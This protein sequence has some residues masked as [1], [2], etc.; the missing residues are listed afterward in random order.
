[1]KRI[2]NRIARESPFN[3]RIVAVMSLGGAIAAT[4]SMAAV[5]MANASCPDAL[6]LN[7][8]TGVAA[9][10]IVRRRK[11]IDKVR[12][13]VRRDR[14]KYVIGRFVGAIIA[15]R[16]RHAKRSEANQKSEV[17]LGARIKCLRWSGVSRA[18]RSGL[19]EAIAAQQAHCARA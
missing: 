14:Q 5:T 8:R 4:T 2:G 7:A 9:R 6:S 3:S 18:H 1:M 11:E 15:Q 17:Q 19:C 12:N 13:F 16:K 10:R